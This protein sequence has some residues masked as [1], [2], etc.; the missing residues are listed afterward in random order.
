MVNDNAATTM[1]A[2]GGF[3]TAVAIKFPVLSK[4]MGFI[5]SSYPLAVFF[6]MRDPT[7]NAIFSQDIANNLANMWSLE[8]SGGQCALITGSTPIGVPPASVLIC[9]GV[10]NA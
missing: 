3:A 9:C 7:I 5:S 6:C 10:T 8:Q 1:G 2:P 4:L